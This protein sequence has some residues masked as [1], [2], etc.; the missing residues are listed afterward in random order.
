MAVNST[1]RLAIFTTHPIQ[2][3]CPL[4]RRLNDHCGIKPRVFFLSDFS[5]RTYQD[6]EFG[7][8]VKWTVPLLEGYD[9]EVFQHDRPAS[10]FTAGPATL[11]RRLRAFAPQ[12]CLLNGYVP[13]FYWHALAACRLL[14]VP[15]ILRTEATDVDKQRPMLRRTARSVALRSFYSQISYFLAIGHNARSH[16]LRLGVPSERIGFSPYCVD[17]D[18]FER[19]RQAA[20]RGPLRRALGIPEAGVAILF[21]G[22]LIPKK[23]PGLVLD[24]VAPVLE[25]AGKPIHVVF[26]GDGE[27]RSD[28]ERRAASVGSG[29]V[30]FLGF[31]NQ[32]QM[33]EVYANCDLLVLPSRYSETWG[34]VVNEGLQFGLP[35][36]VSD[37]VGCG[38]D[39]IEEG[40]TGEIFPAG[41]APTLRQRIVSMVGKLAE[42][43][44]RVYAACRAKAADYSLDR[45][46]DGVCDAVHSVTG[47]RG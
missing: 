29:R 45:S 26:M 46:V 4:W 40:L 34:L 47:T 25:V 21:S 11:A 27:L 14:G 38:P 42:N 12:A 39:L 8:A 23:D 10:S 7:R 15:V 18:L 2:Y 13:L 35:A 36:I 1:I 3:Q 17:S 19:Q 32:E 16:Y 30:H 33:G 31:R 41:D 28:L 43:N 6:K 20:V 37:R 5:A 24:A 9:F 22:K 44:G